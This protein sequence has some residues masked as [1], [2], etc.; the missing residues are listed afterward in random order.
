M[1]HGLLELGAEK[2]TDCTDLLR[3]EEFIQLP[4]C[5]GMMLRIA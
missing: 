5:I 2:T 1:Q 4:L 3:I